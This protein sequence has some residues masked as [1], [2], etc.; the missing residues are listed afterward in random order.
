MSA[1]SFP[2]EGISVVQSNLHLSYTPRNLY[3]T[4]VSMSSLSLSHCGNMGSGLS[5]PF[6]VHHLGLADVDL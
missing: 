3:K 6:E 4:I 5:A 2:I 1:L